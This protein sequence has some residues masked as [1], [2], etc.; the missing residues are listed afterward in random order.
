MVGFL[1]VALT[2]WSMFAGAASARPTAIA[3]GLISSY[4]V[5]LDFQ[6]DAF[7]AGNQSG[8]LVELRS[9]WSGAYSTPTTIATGLDYPF[10]IAVD[11]KDDVFMAEPASGD[12]VEVPSNG[13]GGYDTPTTVDSGLSY[14]SAVGV[15]SQGDLFI[16][17]QTNTYGDGS[18]V[19][20]PSNGSGGYDT[21]T[22]LDTGLGYPDG[23][24][25]DSHDDVF[26]T[27]M[28]NTSYTNGTGN[29]DV[30]EVPSNGSGGYD[31]P[32]TV[33]SGLSSP[34]GVAV[35]SAGDVFTVA[36]GDLVEVPSNGSGGY[37]TATTIATGLSPTQV[38][39]DS[40][41]DVFTTEP[42]YADD[43]GHVLELPLPAN[44]AL[45]GISGGPGDGT[46][47]ASSGGWSGGPTGYSY[48]WYDC[49]ASAAGTSVADSSCAA[50]SGATSPSYTLT[51]D[52]VGQSVEV[53]VTAFDEGLASTPVD[54]IAT[55][56]L[57]PV[58]ASPSNLNFGSQTEGQ[59]SPVSWLEVTNSGSAPLSFTGPAT[60]T[61]GSDFTIPSGD[62]LC[63]GL[64]LEPNQSCWV[65]VQFEPESTAAQ[66]ATLTFGTNNADPQPGTVS[67]SG[68]G[69][70]AQQGQ[71]GATGATGA[72]GSTGATGATGPAGPKGAT[73]Q[74]GPAGQDDLLMCA[75]VRVKGKHGKRNLEKC[76]L[77]H[78][79]NRVVTGSRPEPAR[80]SRGRTMYGFGW[81][82][83]MA[84]G[85]FELI[86]T[87]ER[88][89]PGGSY[90]LTLEHAKG[91]KLV[92]THVTI[93]IG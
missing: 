4:G 10:G 71:Q 70:A 93:M 66:N 40:S 26:I 18:V 91:R 3:T 86:L 27:N 56:A 61:A 42:G 88:K 73:G 43:P 32:T 81:S 16:S 90:T 41:G 75:L 17:V 68:T 11:S 20:L 47:T 65:G 78:T 23:V 57:E 19:E 92:F 36:N 1:V 5:A 55:S 58:L 87:A 45:P 85:R 82:I 29:G 30:V 8:E 35:D 22:T 34:S 28:G 51:N 72:T 74:T 25:V 64:T 52:D 31:T 89:M 13:S 21:P 83:S 48:Q 24:A 7:V 14:P 60:S 12:V 6:G 38:A 49:S 59:A 77:E 63:D 54:S 15:D 2:S 46:L 79:K 80:V 33:D 44:S 67:L 76:S 62:D 84:S 53:E 9:N 50:I 69:V 37:D 39:V